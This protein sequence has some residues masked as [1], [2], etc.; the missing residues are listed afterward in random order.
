MSTQSLV[1]QN[2]EGVPVALPQKLLSVTAPSDFCVDLF[3]YLTEKKRD[4]KQPLSHVEQIAYLL[5]SLEPTIMIGGLLDVYYQEYS[6]G[7]IAILQEYLR[8][9]GLCKLASIL[10]EGQS[11]YTQGRADI[12]EGEYREI[13][14]FTMGEEIGARL[15]EL[16]EIMTAEDGELCLVRDRVYEDVKANSVP[17]TKGGFRLFAWRPH[18]V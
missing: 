4:G 5:L 18:R 12:T 10:A 1:E 6:L 3:R 17:A 9:L 14:P 15:A 7:E 8:R 16:Q 13:Y 11:L 2:V